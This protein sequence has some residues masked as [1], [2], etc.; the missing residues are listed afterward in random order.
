MA[1]SI[2]NSYGQEPN[3][4]SN[5]TKY[6]SS[7]G[8][9]LVIKYDLPVADTSQLFSISLRISYLDKVIQP[10]ENSLTGSWGN[11]ISP[12]VDKVILWD[13]PDEL[14]NDINK[15]KVEVIASKLNKPLA[16]FEYKVTNDKPPFE[17]RF[18]NQSKNA[19]MYSWKFGDSKS[20]ENNLSTQKSPVHVFKSRGAYNVRLTAGSK[21]TYTVDSI[22]KLV[23]LGAG[24]EKEIQKHKTL[25][26]IFLGSAVVSAGVGTLFLVKSGSLWKDWTTKGNP[27]LKKKSNT[28]KVIGMS[29]LAVTAV[30]VAGVVIQTKKIKS[31][32]P[33]SMNYIPLRKGGVVGLAW[34]F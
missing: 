29:A 9:Q 4:A 1:I 20:P 26:T 5:V 23:T 15:V 10:G 18:E 14:K 12:G 7:E 3:F 25:K 32:K 16:K 24:N 6:P 2:Y 22:M 8:N 27:D 30:S 34:N 21:G 17:V 33:L 19:D 28:D 13:F 31:T 11:N